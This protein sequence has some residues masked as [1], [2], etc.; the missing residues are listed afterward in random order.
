[1]KILF[2]D[3]ISQGH[4]D[5]LR[6]N[7]HDV[8]MEPSLRTSEL[9]QHLEGA[10]V[11]VVRSTKVDE[12]AIIA[13][14]QLGLVVRAGAGTDNIDTEAASRRGVYVC[15]V[16]GRNAVAVAELT[17]GLLLAIDRRICDNVA[18]LRVGVWNKGRYSS[19]DGILGTTMAIVGV[20]DIGLAVAERAR[21]FGMFVTALRR[22]GR[23]VEVQSRIRSIGIRLVDD[24]DELLADANVVSIHVPKASDTT[25]L[26]DASFLSKMQDGAILLNTSRPDVVD[27]AAL[28]QVLETKQLRAGLDVWPSEP[29]QKE[30]SFSSE[31]GRHPRV[32]GTHHIG[33]STSQAQDSVSAGTIEVIE[34]Y[35]RGRVINCVNL[36]QNAVGTNY[37]TIRHLDRVGVLAQIFQVLRSNGLNVQQVQNQIFSGAAAA[38]ATV[39]ING[40][41]SSDVLDQLS[42][43]DEVLAAASVPVDGV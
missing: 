7:G 24:Y 40:Y 34:A 17:M 27:E 20:G 2:A 21:A 33:A 11:L 1:M 25:G 18:D 15:N 26:V 42:A 39:N 23:S 37:L 22:E 29:S 43:I 10:D 35:L 32:I 13:S 5:S 38:V 14:D 3:A 31:L 12:A 16:P 28:L 4:V 19:A 41:A 9:P 36:D 8:V 6:R 30:G